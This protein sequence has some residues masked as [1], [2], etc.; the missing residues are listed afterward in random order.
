[1]SAARR[2]EQVRHVL[3]CISDCLRA[4]LADH[5]TCVSSCWVGRA[6]R[7]GDIGMP[8]IRKSIP[9]LHVF[10]Y[11]YFFGM[12]RIRCARQRCHLC[13]VWRSPWS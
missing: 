2:R 10:F 4:R 5:G 7:S 11:F 8:F 6:A 1:M 12:R 9:A 13:H 3:K